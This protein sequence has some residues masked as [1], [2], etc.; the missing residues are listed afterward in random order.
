MGDIAINLVSDAIWLP[1]GLLIGWASGYIFKRYRT[2]GARGFWAPFLKGSGPLAIILTDKQGLLPR[3]PRKVSITDVQAYSDVRSV[4]NE[5]GR[6]VEIKVR[7]EADIAQLSQ[8]CFVSLGGPKANGISEAV[9]A[10]LGSRLPVA[11]DATSGCFF[12]RSLTLCATYDPNQ[13]VETDYGLIVRLKRFDRSLMNSKST[14]VVFGLHGHGTEQA[15]HAIS[16][17]VDLILQMKQY[18][19]RDSYALLEFK[20]SNHKCV[21][22]KLIGSGEIF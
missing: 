15:V 8:D 20:F 3:S 2:R 1:I 5:L 17:N 11:F 9:L 13:L 7:S 6:A 10:K 18:L 22:S 14:L 16:N 4:L 12:Y 21:A 19:D